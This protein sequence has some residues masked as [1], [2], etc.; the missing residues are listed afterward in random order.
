MVKLGFA[1]D[2]FEWFEKTVDLPR[3]HPPLLKPSAGASH[4]AVAIN[5]KVGE[6]NVP[7]IVGE[8]SKTWGFTGM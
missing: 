3:C 6:K 2:P 8:S 7:G 1:Y 4:R 5:L